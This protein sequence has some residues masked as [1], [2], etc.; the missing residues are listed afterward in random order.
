[1]YNKRAVILCDGEPPVKNLLSEEIC[2]SDLFIAADGGAQ[3]A[4]GFDILPDVIIG[5]MDSFTDY[6]PKTYPVIKDA[7]QETNDLEKALNYALENEVSQITVLGATGKRIDHTL[8]NLS[9]LKQFTSK[10]SSIY[11]KDT[12]GI[13]FILPK[14]Y[15]LNEPVGTVISLFPLSGVV[16]GIRTEGLKFPLNEESLENGVR[17]GSSNEISHYPAQIS[18]EDGDLLIFIGHHPNI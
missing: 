15:K 7:D 18:H 16:T 6:N 13:Y 8:K 14:I 17:D 5:D 4:I 9:V 2:I 10:F 3:T 1:M 11:F 12:Y